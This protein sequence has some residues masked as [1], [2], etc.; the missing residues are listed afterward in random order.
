MVIIY[1]YSSYPEK[2]IPIS[3]TFV[4]LKIRFRS[5][6]N[7]FGLS[8]DIEDLFIHCVTSISLN[9]NKVCRGRTTYISTDAVSRFSSLSCFL[10]ST[11]LNIYQT[12]ILSHNYV[13]YACLLPLHVFFD[14]V[15]IPG[16]FETTLGSICTF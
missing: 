6:G 12:N 13:R 16:H 7:L 5:A 3:L 1:M 8:E 9:L 2:T 11:K 4:V 10:P 14:S 15:C